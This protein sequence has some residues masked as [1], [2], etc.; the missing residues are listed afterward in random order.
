MSYI[1]SI[2]QAVADRLAPFGTVGFNV[3][4]L[5]EVQAEYD[6]K[7]FLNGEITVAY[8]SSKFDE[9]NDIG[10][11]SSQYEDIMIILAIRSRFLRGTK[12]VYNIASIV[13][14]YLV[15]F[16][17]AGYWPMKAVEMGLKDA[18]REDALW[19]YYATYQTRAIAVQE[20]DAETAPNLLKIILDDILTGDSNEVPPQT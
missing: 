16:R 20:T 17:P 10:L 15:G 12:G 8:H 3:R 11:G 18:T 14:R 5:P 1:E 2:E 7:V 4:V 9:R 13:R 6:Q 19:T